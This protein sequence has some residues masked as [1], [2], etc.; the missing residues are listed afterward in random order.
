MNVLLNYLI[1]SLKLQDNDL[2]VEGGEI[3]G[4]ALKQNK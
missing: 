4:A 3:I 1:K 2:G